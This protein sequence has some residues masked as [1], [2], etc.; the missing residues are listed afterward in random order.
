MR[1]QTRHSIVYAILFVLQTFLASSLFWMIFPIFLRV[2]RNLGE[3]QEFQPYGAR[4]IVSSAIVLQ[5]CYWTRYRWFPLYTPFRNAFIGHLLKFAS[6]IGFFFGGA[7]FSVILF[8]HVPELDP[9]PPLGQA[10]AKGLCVMGILFALFCYS[11]ELERLGKA[12][13]GGE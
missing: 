8:R 7:L 6:R 5:C 3:Q 9:L 11:L 10:L 12:F 2:M 13:E 4:A 1:Q